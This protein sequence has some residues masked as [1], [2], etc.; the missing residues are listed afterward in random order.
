MVAGVFTVRV[1]PL[2]IFVPD[3][4]TLPVKVTVPEDINTVPAPV[5]LEA[6]PKV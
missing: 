3:R 2:M 6:E 5:T 1:P 4:E